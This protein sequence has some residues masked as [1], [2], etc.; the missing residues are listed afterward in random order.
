MLRDN[1]LLPSEAIRLTALGILSQGPKRYADLA[2]EVRHFVSRITGP[3]L[4]LMGSSL[5][6]LRYEGLVEARASAEGGVGSPAPDT[7]LTITEAGRREMI[8]LLRSPIR[9]P[10]NDVNKLI[11]ALKMWFLHLLPSPDQRVQVDMLMEICDGEL[12]RLQDLREHHPDE[13]GSLIAWI[14][15]DIGQLRQRLDWFRSL[16]D[17][18]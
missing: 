17:K 14:D 9:G 3:S 6:L 1:A 13:P 8:E 15:H 18:V 7:E 12:A 10:I 2:A 4:D 11:I 16:R 5:E